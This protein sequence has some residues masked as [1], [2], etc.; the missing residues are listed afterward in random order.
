MNIYDILVLTKQKNKF[1]Y[2][3]LIHLS[4]LNELDTKKVQD[5]ALLRLIVQSHTHNKD[6][7]HNPRD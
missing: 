2:S 6:L 3:D 5:Y 4:R 7:I 1:T